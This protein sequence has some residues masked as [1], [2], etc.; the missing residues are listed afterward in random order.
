MKMPPTVR[1]ERERT[2]I[3][4]IL[5]RLV[6]ANPC[7]GAAP[8]AEAMEYAVMGGGQRLRPL[9]ALQVGQMTGADES[10]VLKGAAGVELLHCASL[11]VDDLPCMDDELMRRG[12][13][14]GQRKVGEGKG[15]CRIG[16]VQ[17]GGAGGAA[18]RRRDL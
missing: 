15:K 12:G 9:L 8:V 11:I 6:R 2:L 10:L 5:E 3:E 7:P 14:G 18:V 4:H 17:P 13:E 16:C 1:F